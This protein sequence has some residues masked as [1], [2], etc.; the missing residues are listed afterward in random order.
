MKVFVTGASAGIG[1][2]LVPELIVA[3]HEVLGLAR[4]DASAQV[5]STAGPVCCAVR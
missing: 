1:S 4:P 5:V 2:P 3:G